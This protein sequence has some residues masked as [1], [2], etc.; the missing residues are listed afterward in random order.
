M[1][2]GKG[3]TG[4]TSVALSLAMKADEKVTLIDADVEAPNAA[5]LLGAEMETIDRAYKKVPRIDEEKCIKCGLCAKACPVAALVFIPGKIPMFFENNC[6][7]CMLC[8]DVCPVNAIIEERVEIGTVRAGRWRHITIYDGV[9]REG[10]EE[11]TPLVEKLLNVALR[12]AGK[13]VIIDTAAGIHYNVARA[14]MPADRVIIVT[15]PTPYGVHDLKKAV[16]LVKKLDK[17][18]EIYANKWGIHEGFQRK[19]EEIA[20][21]EGVSLT[22]I[23]YSD[24]VLRSYAQ[25]RFEA[26]L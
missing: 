16:G 21:R 11:A 18:F 14:I 15:E 9:L 6:V 24:D 8:K 22:K 7:G 12:K 19:I 5:I 3:G 25:G 17:P 4:K 13:N 1:T 10:E 2:G 23:P 20:R 26:I